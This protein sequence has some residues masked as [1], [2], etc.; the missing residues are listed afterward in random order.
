VEGVVKTH[1]LEKYY[2]RL[3]HWRLPGAIYFVTFNL[4]Q[5]AEQ[6]TEAERTLIA[7][8]LKH[9]HLAHYRLY[10][11]VVM[12]DH[13]HVVVQPFGDRALGSI[14]KNW[15]SY[16]AHVIQ[17]MRG[18]AG[19]LWQKDSYDRIIRDEAELLEKLQY[20]MDNPRR[21]WPEVRDYQWAEWLPWD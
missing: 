8:G 17:K 3:P 2:N 16:T 14:L 11:Y 13:V 18:M 1:G 10:G 6:L 19:S 20:M 12:D 4:I 9:F 15:K 7:I 21:R 5:T